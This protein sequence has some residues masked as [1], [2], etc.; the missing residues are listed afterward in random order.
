VWNLISNAIKFTPKGGT[1]QVHLQRID[2]HI[3]ISV[4]DTGIG[5]LPDF[6]P[7]VFDRFRQGDSSATRSYRGLGLGL[8]IVKS[9][10]E[11]HGGSV[12]VESAGKDK[13][14]TFT[15]HLPLML[16]RKTTDFGRVHPS[17][18]STSMVFEQA[19]LSELKV[20][21]VD[22]EP[23]ARVLLNY[24]FTV[25]G[26]TVFE[27]GNAGDALMLVEKE[28]PHILICDIGMPDVDGY[29][30]IRRVRALGEA[31]GGK[32]V[33]IALTAFARP[34]DRTRALRAGFLVHVA[35]PVDPSEIVATVA[36]IAGRTAPPL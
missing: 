23:D 27:A 4:C 14:S 15:I 26:A 25:C 5:I 24:V 16:L 12:H 3:E 22:D 18:S 2:S 1:V 35:K 28:R 7:Y 21:V 8:S 34:E 6:L 13:G 11:L 9:L 10:V 31:R 19:N 33:A 20:L 32:V 17:A 36:S 29:E 30:L